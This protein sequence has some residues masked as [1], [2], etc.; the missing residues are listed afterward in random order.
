MKS[1]LS[2]LGLSKGRAERCDACCTRLS[3]RSGIVPRSI[4]RAAVAPTV[5]R[6]AALALAGCCL[7]GPLQA[8][9]PEDV[10]KQAQQYERDNQLPKSAE[11]YESFLR[12]FADHSQ[13][14]EVHFRLAKLYDVLGRLDEMEKHL[15]AVTQ[16]DRKQFR[17]RAECF[18]LLAKHD[19][20]CKR[21]EEAA[22]LLESI[23]GEGTAGLYEEESLSLC[24][25]YYAILKKTDDA[26]A[27]LNLLRFRHDSPY[28]ES[29]AQKLAVLWLNAGRLDLAMNAISE[30]A[31]TYPNHASIPDLLLR[32][33]DACREAKK[34][35]ASISLCEQIQAR[36]PKALEA[37][38][39]RVLV[40][41]C[42]RDQKRFQEAAG[43]FDQV[44][45]SRD[46]QAR[47][48]AAEALTQAAELHFTELHDADG[49]VPRFEEAAKLARDSESENKTKLLELCY[50]R[51]GET[52]FQRKNWAA[53]RENYL[54]LRTLGSGLNVAPRIIA[55]EQELKLASNG[56]Q[57]AG[58][59]DVQEMRTE[60][61]RNPGTFR[62][63][64]LEVFLLDRTVF[65]GLKRQAV[66]APLAAE[67]EKLLATY[68]K[69]VLS[70]DNL[71]TYIRWQ[72]SVCRE[73]SP[74]PADLQQAA[75]GFEQ[76]A[77]SDP[78]NRL[79][80]RDN[81]LEHLALTSERA[82]DK[83]RALRTYRELYRL[84]Q[85]KLETQNAPP[86]QDAE[87]RA[88]EYLKCLVTRADTPDLM[89]DAIALTRKT[90]E[91]CG[92]ASD[93]S[94]EARLYLGDLYLLQRDTGAAVKVFQEFLTIYGPRQGADGNF[95]DGPLK[96]EYP[97]DEKSAQLFEAAI[98]LAHCWYIERHEQN[99]AKAYE[100]I[101]RNL[102][103]GNKY[104]A[105]A[106]YGRALELSK[107]KDAQTP[108]ARRKYA[109]TLWFWVVGTSTDFD[110]RDF[111]QT[112]RYWVRPADDAFAE[113]QGYVKNAILRAG[114]TWSET[115]HPELAA[116]AF[117]KF[118]QIYGQ[119]PKG[120]KAGGIRRQSRNVRV[121][122]VD[123]DVE[124]AR[125]ALGRELIT[126]NQFQR[127]GQV[128]KPYLSGLRDSR[129]RTSALLLLAYHAGKAGLLAVAIEAYATIL[130]EY[131]EN[132]V[133][134][135]GDIVPLPAA[136]RLRAGGYNW[137]GI[138]FEPPA[139]LDLAEVRYSLGYLYW[140]NEAWGSC[141]QTLSPFLTDASLG[142][143]KV[144]DRSL[145][146]LG[147][148]YDRSYNPVP[149]G[150]VMLKLIDR[151]PKFEALEEVYVR[152]TRD[153][154]E[155]Q[156]WND[157]DR[158]CR[159]F[160]LKWPRSD[161]RQRME[162]F[163]ALRMRFGGGKAEAGVSTLRGLA[164]G[165]TFEDVKAD[166]WYWLGRGELTNQP[167]Q[168]AQALADFEQSVTVFAREPAC[169]EA[170]RC[171]MKLRQWT[172]AKV[173]LDRVLS[174]FAKGDPAVV[175]QARALLPDVMKEIAR[176]K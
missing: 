27:K 97:P 15:T 159:E 115:G 132:E 91:D 46:V 145:Y 70:Q 44:A 118:L 12:E 38:S 140:K 68:P 45:A 173:H 88:R 41:L 5:R 69:D 92:P 67:Y 36:Y 165:E 119:D 130:D 72:A 50:F 19:A 98:R 62:S 9:A 134:A 51:L 40:G 63:L 29:A 163:G 110:S 79:G 109:D 52:Y 141:I 39:A 126:L 166:A 53:A 26:A 176:S 28:A 161:R 156:A 153:A 55:C 171:A 61:A 80:Y 142:Q 48:I 81:A 108:E 164:N 13:A 139:K 106:Q 150:Q 35:D 34:Y 66:V 22:K 147:Q 137:D 151:F 2:R 74:E 148:S 14:V 157:V 31:Q 112:L 77:A 174:E 95:A 83:P 18:V 175:Q 85:A 49:A 111:N 1:V 169:I 155:A 124:T 138:R 42:D 133:T 47:G 129:F 37:Q 103:N 58:A 135:R 120:R 89:A 64:E 25:G 121:N 65:D 10:F 101:N 122:L 33:A 4:D 154:V 102:P 160:A 20:S 60:I 128:Y 116:G 99:L 90:I 76:V 127:L 54:Q 125:Y 100:W 94:R 71:Q 114:Q 11:A 162:L 43:I 152:A 93:L 57:T 117:E 170:A 131:G 59:G 105:E 78:E 6:L 84:T 107:G 104:M 32:A 21:Y 16:S 123:N 143:A 17:N 87:K 3:G 136:E 86:G 172:Q 149:A 113:Q 96:V 168:Y 56:P 146:M 75:D 24:A 144:A 23:L 7:A 73:S 158:L 30:F 8:A 82:G 167:P